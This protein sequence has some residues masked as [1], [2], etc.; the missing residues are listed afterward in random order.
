VS[1]RKAHLYEIETRWTGNLGEGTAGYRAYG[2]DHE[3]TGEG[4]AC[5][6][7]GSSDPAFRGDPSRYSPEELLV[8]SL[9]ACHM[10]WLLHL[11]ADAG[12]VVTAYSDRAS[13]SMVEAGDG[14]GHFTEV[15][16]RPRVMI[17]DTNRIEEATALHEQAHRLCFIARSVRF[18]VRHQ[19]VVTA[20]DAPSKH[21]ARDFGSD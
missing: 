18:P 4:K 13:G 1:P 12:I 14:S 10:L 6:L 17:T 19:P 9:S 8:A 21:A 20:Q 3:I 16:L 2:R 15:I 5:L 7:P 11:C